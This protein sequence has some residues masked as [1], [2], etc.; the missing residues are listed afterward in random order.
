MVSGFIRC[1]SSLGLRSCLL[2]FQLIQKAHLVIKRIQKIENIFN[3][4]ECQSQLKLGGCL[5]FMNR[6]VPNEPK[7][8]EVFNNICGKNSRHAVDFLF[9]V[10][11]RDVLVSAYPF[12]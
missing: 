9:K 10:R 12:Y 8:M 6:V 11:T 1:C 4:V 7:T 2:A 5:K 3:Y